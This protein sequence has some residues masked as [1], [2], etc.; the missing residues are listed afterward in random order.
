[1]NQMNE[2][3]EGAMF[4]ASE[5]YSGSAYAADL[6]DQMEMD[7]CLSLSLVSTLDDMSVDALSITVMAA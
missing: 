6:L 5:S 3:L 4:A 2:C 1:M 7:D